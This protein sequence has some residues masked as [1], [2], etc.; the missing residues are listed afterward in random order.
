MAQAEIRT[1]PGAKRYVQFALPRDAHLGYVNEFIIPESVLP[2]IE[3]VQLFHN[4]TIIET[5][6]PK[7]PTFAFATRRPVLYGQD[8]VGFALREGT[9]FPWI[10]MN[11]VTSVSV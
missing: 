9:E 5:L 10:R 3:A 2:Q 11:Y 6:L 1:E 4:G 7:T 8:F